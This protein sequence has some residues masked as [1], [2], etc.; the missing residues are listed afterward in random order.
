MTISF[1][2]PKCGNLCAFPDKHAGKRARCMKCQQVFIIPDKD[3]Q[4][5]EK[6][7]TNPPNHDPL[8]GFYHT[9]FINSWKIFV[10]PANATGL[11]FVATAVCLKFFA[12]HVDYSF[13]FPGFRFQAPLGLIISVAVWGALFWYYMEII[14]STAFE[15]DQLPETYMGDFFGFVCN[16]VK[17][18]YLFLLALAIAELPFYII[19]SMLKKAGVETPWLGHVLMVAG[20]FIFPMVVLALSVGRDMCMVFRPDYIF[21]PI[22]R[23]LWPYVVVTGLVMVAALLQWETVGYGRIIGE[24]KSVVAMHLT[25]NIAVQALLLIAVRAIGLFYRHYSCYFRW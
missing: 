3:G 14:C 10:R 23:A 18:V 5:P 1:N 20:L 4:K 25:A 21:M 8:P 12:G 11:V 7:K 2:C 13:N 16:I 17:C 24:S 22:M 15:E 19:L 6:L 9:V